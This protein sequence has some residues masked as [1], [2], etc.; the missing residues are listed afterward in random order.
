MYGT[1][2]TPRTGVGNCKNG[3]ITA[4]SGNRAA[5]VHEGLIQLPQALTFPTPDPPNPMPPTTDLNCRRRPARSLGLSGA[6]CSGA[7]GDLTLDALGGTMMFGN[8]T[9]E[10]RRDASLCARARTT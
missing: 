6:A 3:A 5:D 1:L 9:S 7:A 2:S 4:L 8:V 10:R